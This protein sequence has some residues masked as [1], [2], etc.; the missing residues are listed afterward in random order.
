MPCGELKAFNEVSQAEFYISFF[1]RNINFQKSMSVTFLLCLFI[2]FN[3]YTAF[4]GIF[5]P[6]TVPELRASVISVYICLFPCSG[7]YKT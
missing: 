5:G 7:R 1:V 6:Q 4:I 2:L 3:L